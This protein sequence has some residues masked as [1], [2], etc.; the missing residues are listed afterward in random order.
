MHDDNYQLI[1]KD[2][3]EPSILMCIPLN[4]ISSSGILI[5]DS[6]DCDHPPERSED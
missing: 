2:Q 1:G 4:V 6:G 5:T 3:M